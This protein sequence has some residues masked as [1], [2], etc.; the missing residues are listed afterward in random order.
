MFFLEAWAK[1]LIISSA[2]KC[3][4]IVRATLQAQALWDGQFL[5]D[6]VQEP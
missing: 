2:E 1:S 3:S 5:P 6:L 4:G